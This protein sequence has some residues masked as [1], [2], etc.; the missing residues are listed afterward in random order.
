L[1]APPKNKT[2]G[3]TPEEQCILDLLDGTVSDGNE[4]LAQSKLA[5]DQYNQALVMLEITGKVR[6]VGNNQWSAA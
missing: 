1:T 2:T 6:S 5:L 3:S 4:L